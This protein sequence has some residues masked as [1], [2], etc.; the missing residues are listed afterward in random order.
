MPKKIRCKYGAGPITNELVAPWKTPKPTKMPRD[1][2]KKKG[3]KEKRKTRRERQRDQPEPPRWVP[4]DPSPRTRATEDASH[5]WTDIAQ[6]NIAGRPVIP[7]WEREQP[8]DPE[9]QSS[10]GR[11]ASRAVL[12]E[13]RVARRDYDTIRLRKAPRGPKP[14]VEGEGEEAKK[15]QERLRR[16]E[17]MGAAGGD[18]HGAIEGKMVDEDGVERRVRVIIAF[19]D[20]DE[21]GYAW[22][23]EA[24]C[25]PETFKD[26]PVGPRVC[27]D[28]ARFRRIWSGELDSDKEDD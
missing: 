2:N 4:R 27:E 10:F 14:F 28:G 19:E 23:D 21:P 9:T 7:G 25:D 11:A 6:L 8:I 18:E 24:L 26:D 15:E 22:V 1:N 13:A 20:E 5:L 17:E 16:E 12:P 3:D